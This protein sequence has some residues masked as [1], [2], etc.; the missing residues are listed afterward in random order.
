MRLTL[1]G[2]EVLPWISADEAAIRRLLTNLIDNA[3]KYSGGTEIELA[4][5]LLEGGGLSI[6]VSD[7]G[8]GVDA[9]ELREMIK[10]GAR[11][12]EEPKGDDRGRGIGLWLVDTFMSAHGGSVEF[13]RPNQGPGIRVSLNFPPYRTIA[14]PSPPGDDGPASD[15]D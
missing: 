2:F 12:E 11:S 5:R 15:Q 13:G 9:D 8:R 3:V 14:T 10:F 4:G 6:S 1:T 7:N